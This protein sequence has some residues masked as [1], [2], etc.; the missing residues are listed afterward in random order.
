M[1]FDFLVEN[2]EI[3][4]DSYTIKR[5]ELVKLRSDAVFHHSLPAMNIAWPSKQEDWMLIPTSDF[6]SIMERLLEYE[7][8]DG[9]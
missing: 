9:L 4:A 8:K 1:K 2:R 3:E 7:A 5:K 6:E